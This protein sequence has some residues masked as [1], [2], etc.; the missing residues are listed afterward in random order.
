[1]EAIGEGNPCKIADRKHESKS[2][3]SYVHLSK[4][5]RLQEPV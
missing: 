1:L 3:G 5:T 2:I 4:N